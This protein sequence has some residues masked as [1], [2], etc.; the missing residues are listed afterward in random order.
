[1]SPPFKIPGSLNKGYVPPHPIPAFLRLKQVIMSLKPF[2][3]VYLELG[4]LG[5]EL[6][7]Q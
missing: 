4:L 7:L 2:A 5:T 1:M 6:F 3:L